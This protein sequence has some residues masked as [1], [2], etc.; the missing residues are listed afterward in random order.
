MTDIRIY[1]EGAAGRITLT[2]PGA[3][4]ALSYDMCLRIE[5]AL[6]FWRADEAVRLV[7]I[8]ATGDKAFCAGGDIQEMYDTGIAGNFD[9]GRKFWADEYRM[10]TKIAEY[11]KPVVAFMQ[12]YTMGGGVGLGGH[13]SHRIVCETSQIA[14]P[15]VGI[16]LVPDVGGTLLLA[17]APGRFGEY[18]GATA[19]RMSGAEAILTGFADHFVPREYWL[20]LISSLEITGD[21]SKI[22]TVAET[23]PEAPI[24]AHRAEIDAAFAHPAGEIEAALEAMDGEFAAKTLK[25]LRR[26]SPLAVAVG[27][28]N[29]AR[30]RAADNIRDTLGF[31]YEYTFRA[32]EHGDFLEGIRAMIIDKDKKPTW[33]HPSLAEVSAAEIN[34]LTAPLGAAALDLSEA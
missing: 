3:L 26:A 23:R 31:E 30:A 29:I 32:M 27:L 15:E 11:P 2:R 24:A 17:R 22:D 19:A 16:G 9:Y 33:K 20:D 13:A 10:N 5:Q 14:M 7:V 8:D 28:V 12:G 4:N 25:A 6:D 34:A 1:T 21:V 18:Y